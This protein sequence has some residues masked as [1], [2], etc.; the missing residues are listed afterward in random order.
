MG[1]EAQNWRHGEENGGKEH[2]DRE[3]GPQEERD[4]EEDGEKE[5]ERKLEKGRD[6][7]TE[8]GRDTE[9]GNEGKGTEQ[10]RQSDIFLRGPR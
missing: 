2:R 7:D 4:G 8:R 6:R 5:P 3:A 9:D 1:K 10:H